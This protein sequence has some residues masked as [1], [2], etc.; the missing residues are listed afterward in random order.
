[1]WKLDLIEVHNRD[2]SSKAKK[3]GDVIRVADLDKRNREEIKRLGYKKKTFA[4]EPESLVG[5]HLMKTV[6]MNRFLET[7]HFRAVITGIRWDEQGAREG[8]SY[9]SW[10]GDKFT[11]EHM[12]IHPILHLSERDIWDVTK[13]RGI[14]YCSLYKEGYRSLGAKGTTNKADI[15]PAWEQDFDKVGERAGRRQDKEEIMK[16]LRDLGYM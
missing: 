10:R 16:R 14:P 9:N 4:F 8:E 6:A 15:K 7:H 12:R 5:N 1:M 13:T 2:V 11:P 3:I